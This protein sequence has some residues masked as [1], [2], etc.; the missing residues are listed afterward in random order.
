MPVRKR[1]MKRRGDL[2][3]DEIAWLNGETDCGWVKF[4]H[5]DQLEAL[6]EAHGDAEAFEWRRGMDWPVKCARGS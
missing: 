2:T 1:N 5:W 6:W 4:W 3:A